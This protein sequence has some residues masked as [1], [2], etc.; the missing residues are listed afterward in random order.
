MMFMYIIMIWEIIGHNENYQIVEYSDMG[1]MGNNGTIVYNLLPSN[2][3]EIIG[4]KQD[5]MDRCH[6]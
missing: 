5:T 6:L 3:W 4:D 2:I 1:N